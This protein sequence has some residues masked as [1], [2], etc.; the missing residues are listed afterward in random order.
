M[1]QTPD[2]LKFINQYLQRAQELEKIEP[3]V[4]YYCRYYAARQAIDRGAKSPESQAF[5]VG[6]LDKLEQV[7][8]VD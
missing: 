2:E 6:L 3:V 8:K 1:I 5:L 4:S 7:L